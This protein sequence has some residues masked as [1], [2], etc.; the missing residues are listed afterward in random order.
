[1]RWS[2]GRIAGEGVVRFLVDVTVRTEPGQVVFL[3][4]Q[5]Y[6]DGKTVRWSVPLT[7]VPGPAAEPPPQH[8][9]RAL[10]AGVVGLLVIA[11]SLLALGRARARGSLQER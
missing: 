10:T 6:E 5:T 11:G 1:V 4:T 8:L 3:A 2:D 7:V 9:R